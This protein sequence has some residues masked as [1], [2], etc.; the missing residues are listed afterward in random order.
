M[1]ARRKG[2]RA[3]RP[4]GAPERPEEDARYSVG[5]ITRA[6]GLSAHVLRAWERRY[7]AVEPRRT[8]GGTRRYTEADLRRLVLLRRAVEAG[9]SIGAVARLPEA[10]LERML[11]A[12]APSP[13]SATEAVLAAVQRLDGRETDRLL[14]MHFAA[15]GPR[16]FAHQIAIPLLQEVGRRWEGGALGVAEE[17]LVSSLARNLLGAA[18]RGSD[19]AARGVPLL[20]TT[21]SGE[22]HEFGVL[23]GALLA[24]ASGVNAVYLGPDLPAS[25]VAQA[26]SKLRAGGVVLGVVCLHR[27]ETQRYVD[28]LRGLLAPEVEIWLG[29][30]PG[31]DIA[32]APGVLRLADLPDLERR[33]RTWA[34]RP[35]QR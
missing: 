17:H 7:G 2:G 10:D 14:A 9:H 15:L 32:A 29:G 33:A 23:L 12:S 13:P 4:G 27:R 31:A 18:L 5:A 11:E 30:G 19:A 6:S 35:A 22:R 20:F 34:A 28:E 21:P 24:V 1:S 8:P 26:A 25:D 3:H 16:A